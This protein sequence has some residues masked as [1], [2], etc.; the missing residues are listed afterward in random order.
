MNRGRSHVSKEFTAGRKPSSIAAEAMNLKTPNS[1]ITGT[2]L[3][4]AALTSLSCRTAHQ[5]GWKPI[6]N[7]RSIDGWQMAG[8]GELKLESGELVTYGGMGLL[9]YSREKFGDCRIRVLFK[10]TGANDNSG[11]F[12]RIPE[13]PRDAWDGVNRGYEV[14]IENHGDTWHRTGCLYSISE[15]KH[16]VDARVNEWNTMLI[17]LE[18][19]RTRVQV[20]G[21]LV[22]D[23]SEG[24]PVPPKKKDYEPDRGTRPNLGY[25]GLQNHGDDARVHFREV[26]IAPLR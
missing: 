25:I 7:G 12:I 22:T 5:P 1:F 18:A 20:N 14:Q 8:P 4:L 6:F 10:P 23:Y 2:L 26:S 24:D 13:P 3:G 16:V 9:W 19:K 15:A 21:V 11:V 17:T